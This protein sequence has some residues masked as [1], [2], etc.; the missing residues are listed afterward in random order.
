MIADRATQRGGRSTG[1]A[2]ILGTSTR[3]EPGD[4][5]GRSSS[6]PPPFLRPRPW[7]PWHRSRHRGTSPGQRVRASGRAAQGTSTASLWASWKIP[8]A[9]LRSSR[10]RR[11][12]PRRVQRSGLMRQVGP[13]WLTGVRQARGESEPGEL[14]GERLRGPVRVE[15]AR[16]RQHPHPGGTEWFCRRSDLCPTVPERGP[17]RR[18]T[19]HREPART[20]ARDLV[21]QLVAAGA[22]L[23]DAQLGR[24][25]AG[26]GHHV[27]QAETERRQ[28]LL[29]IR[30]EQP[31]REAGRVQRGPEPVPGASEVVAGR[32][33]PQARVDA[34]EEHR[35]AVAQHVGQP[36]VHRR[37]ELIAGRG[38]RAGQRPSSGSRATATNSK[39]R[40][41]F[42]QWNSRIGLRST[43]SSL[44]AARPS[45]RWDSTRNAAPRITAAAG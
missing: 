16:V 3:W 34:A 1:P 7:P 36:P 41:M 17:V 37:G 2:L 43:T 30:P 18:D 31:G 38:H 44:R 12:H 35:Q 39:E 19:Q 22:E 42:D 21:P 27:G 29:L 40:Y 9:N 23:L 5:P 26:P 32:C 11:H 14:A 15:P 45:S 25:R 6:R 20:M 13:D 24:P 10:R 33:R 8:P 28:Q 4:R